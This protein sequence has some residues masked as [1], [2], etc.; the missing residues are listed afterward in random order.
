M[1]SMPC[2]HDVIRSHTLTKVVYG[3]RVLENSCLYDDIKK[4]TGALTCKN[5]PFYIYYKYRHTL[6][7]EREGIESRVVED[8]LIQMSMCLCMLL[9]VISLLLSAL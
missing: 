4:F 1:S 7:R 8:T 9:H 3:V 5:H 6:N 2:I